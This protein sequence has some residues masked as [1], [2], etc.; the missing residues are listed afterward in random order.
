CLLLK[1]RADEVLRVPRVGDIEKRP[2]PK[3]AVTV[4][5]RHL[6]GARRGDLGGL[7]LLLFA[8]HFDDEVDLITLTPALS[9][10]WRGEI[11]DLHVRFAEDHEQIT[12]AGF[13]EQFVAHRQGG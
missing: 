5:G 12:G 11:F 3:A 7:I 2:A 6:Q 9:L 10:E 4:D 13:L 1:A 8:G